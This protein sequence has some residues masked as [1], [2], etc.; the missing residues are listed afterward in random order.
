MAERTK[1]LTTDADIDAAIERARRYEKF[2]RRVVRASYSR[3]TDR[4][5][6][7]L[8]NGATFTIPRKL[9]QGLDTARPSALAKI[10]LLGPGTALY[11]P[12]LDVAHEVAGLLAGVYGSAKWMDGL[13][14]SEVPERLSA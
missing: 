5:S 2:L 14:W 7:T 12:E 8:D 10:E 13:R 3:R 6:L 9:L 11:W 4:L 1:V